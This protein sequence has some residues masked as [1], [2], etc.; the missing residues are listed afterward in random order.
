MKV[1]LSLCKSFEEKNQNKVKKL[2][3]GLPE[4][5]HGAGRGGDTPGVRKPKTELR[6]SLKCACIFLFYTEFCIFFVS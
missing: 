3:G 5:G 4:E 6:V 2:Q 1:F